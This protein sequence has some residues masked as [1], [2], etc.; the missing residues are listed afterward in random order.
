MKN[1]CY[2]IQVADDN[3]EVLK[4]TYG[5]AQ[6]Y[7]GRYTDDLT[8]QV[9]KDELDR[10]ARAKEGVLPLQETLAETS[11]SFRQAKDGMSTHRVR[12]RL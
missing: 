8:G 5:P 3:L 11:K 9:L 10:E 12:V 7:S 2:G 4:E 6:G 1:G